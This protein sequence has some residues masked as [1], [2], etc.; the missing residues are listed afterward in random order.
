M[1]SLGALMKSAVFLPL[2]DTSSGLAGGTRRPLI[3][4]FMQVFHVF[5][6]FFPMFSVAVHAYE[7]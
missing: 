7:H 5:P 6:M 4:V 1:Q 3:E 2:I